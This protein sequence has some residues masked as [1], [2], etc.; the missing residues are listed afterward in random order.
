MIG[1]HTL[2]PFG[3]HADLKHLLCCS[4]YRRYSLADGIVRKDRW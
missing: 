4:G 3:Q 1:A 2:L